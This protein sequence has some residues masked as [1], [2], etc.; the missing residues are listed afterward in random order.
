MLSTNVAKCSKIDF[1]KTSKNGSAGCRIKELMM[2][3]FFKIQE[4][5]QAKSLK[6]IP[7]PEEKKKTKRGGKRFRKLR[8]RVAMTEIRKYKGRLAFGEKGEDEYRETG[9]GFGMLSS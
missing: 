7:I 1:L 2:Q 5:P 8:E 4:A 6:P 9:K 3:R